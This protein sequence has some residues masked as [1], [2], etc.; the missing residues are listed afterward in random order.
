MSG[1]RIDSAMNPTAPPMSTIISGSSKLVSACTRVS[2]SRVV[3]V[4]DVL[5]HRLELAALLADRDHVRDDRRKRPAALERLGDALALADRADRL[6]DHLLERG[7]AE[8]VLARCP[9]P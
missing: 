9:S 1:I 5:E 6:A 7:V 4:G 2:T 3:G 8:H